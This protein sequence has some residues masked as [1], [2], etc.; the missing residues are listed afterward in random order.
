MSIGSLG[1]VGSL[2]GAPQA[3]KS[4]EV[5][6]NQETAAARE[7]QVRS[8]VSAEDA[9]GIGKTDGE[10]HTATDRDADGRL[11]YFRTHQEQPQPEESAAADDTVPLD[12][13]HA[14]DPTGT[15]GSQLDLT[16]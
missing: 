10:N 15:S 12:A 4:S 7:R 8:E 9:S 2:A 5:A 11:G 1:I 3:G 16:G 13:P 6:K 14:V